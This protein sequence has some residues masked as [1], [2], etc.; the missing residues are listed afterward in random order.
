M[1]DVGPTLVEL[2]G[3]TIAYRQF[4]RSLVQ[5]LDHSESLHR[6]DALSEVHGEVMLQTRE[7]KIVLNANGDPY[8]LYNRVDDPDEQINLA[9]DSACREIVQTLKST[10][11]SRLLASQAMLA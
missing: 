8:L 3:G 9:A 2:A 5:T 10:I 6:E 7:W 4:G 1:L 11:L